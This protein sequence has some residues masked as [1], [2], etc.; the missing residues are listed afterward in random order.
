MRVAVFKLIIAT[1]SQV[2]VRYFFASSRGQHE[3][4]K[5]IYA[6]LLNNVRL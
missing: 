4:N 6:I 5:V 2:I 1:K 3:M